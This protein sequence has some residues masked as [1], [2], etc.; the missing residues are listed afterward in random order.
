LNALVDKVALVNVGKGYASGTVTSS[1]SPSNFAYTTGALISK[2]SVTVTDL[3][4]KPK[5]ILV[6]CEQTTNRF[7]TEYSENTD[8]YYPKTAK[9][10]QYSASS[11]TPTTYNLKGDVLPAS[12]TSDRFTLPVGTGVGGILHTWEAYGE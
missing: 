4:F 9:I 8:S 10:S 2:L 12:V 1:A 7:V 11:Q 3:P 6:Y 5:R